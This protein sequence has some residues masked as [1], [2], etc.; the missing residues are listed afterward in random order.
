M[1]RLAMVIAATLASGS[2]PSASSAPPRLRMRGRCTVGVLATCVGGE[3]HRVL[4]A[5]QLRGGEGSQ[6]EVQGAGLASLPATSTNSTSTIATRTLYQEALEAGLLAPKS[7][8]AATH[9]D[10]VVRAMG[11]SGSTAAE[12]EDGCSSHPTLPS[13]TL[14]L[15]L[16]PANL[17]PKPSTV[18]P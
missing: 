8:E 3:R 14:T 17:N 13:P 18:Q 11:A 9:I 7:F 4:S 16:N 5:L 6:E 2:T 15:T 12:Q 1:W 10:K